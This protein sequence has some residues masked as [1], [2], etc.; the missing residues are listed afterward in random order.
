MNTC[1]NTLIQPRASDRFQNS[2]AGLDGKTLSLWLVDDHDGI[3]DLLADL[4]SG[5]GGIE[6]ARKFSSAEA[7]LDALALE[8]PPDV[9]LTDLNMGGMSG[10]DSILPIK[11]LA[12]STRVF[13]MTTFY[14]SAAA[15]RA[16]KAGASGFLLKRDD[17]ERNVQFILGRSADSE[18]LGNSWS[19]LGWEGREEGFEVTVSNDSL[20]HRK[21]FLN[22]FTDA[23]VAAS[24]DQPLPFLTRARNFFR[25]FLTRNRFQQPPVTSEAS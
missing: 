20:R 5:Y 8:T 1:Y 9:I 25:P 18:W 22:K 15:G 24:P 4:L 2:P 23:A 6:C 21:G 14:D 19:P 16:F 12:R 10:I 17:M 11:R 13:V 7:M 3:R